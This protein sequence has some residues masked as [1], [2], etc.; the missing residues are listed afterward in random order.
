M[1]NK[2][3][4]AMSLADEIAALN[5]GGAK[6]YHEHLPPDDNGL[7]LADLLD[8][9]EA[10]EEFAKPS[11]TIDATLEGELPAEEEEDGE[12]LYNDDAEDDSDA[13][14]SQDKADSEAEQEK[15]K[16]EQDKRAKDA[17]I[18]LQFAVARSH[19]APT[20]IEVH[21]FADDMLKEYNDRF[22]Q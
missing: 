11:D 2:D 6:Q 1:K 16:D 8:T 21:K 17:A 14:S 19:Y 10:L 22:N 20:S 7:T 9:D 3:K 15:D 18:W 12:D 4:S 13:D 5:A